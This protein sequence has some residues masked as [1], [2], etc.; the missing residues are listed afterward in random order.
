MV[1]LY[2]SCIQTYN[3]GLKHVLGVTRKRNL[4]KL[5]TEYIIK[6]W[7]YNNGI[8]I[9]DINDLVKRE[10]KKAFVMGHFDFGGLHKPEYYVYWVHFINIILLCKLYINT[11]W[12]RYEGGT[13]SRESSRNF[14]IGDRLQQ[15]QRS[16]VG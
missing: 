9:S 1:L 16:S 2:R 10:M 3:E 6:L 12:F 8:Q 13:F 4:M 5:L 14:T 11:F 15:S 7:K